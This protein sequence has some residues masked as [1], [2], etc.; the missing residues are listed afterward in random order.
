MT[1]IR[2]T[3]FGLSYPIYSG[4][5]RSLKKTLFRNVRQNIKKI[6]PVGGEVVM[7]N[8]VAVVRALHEITF[9]IH[10]GERVGLIGHNGAGK[11]TLLR[12]IAGIFES[13]QGDLHIQGDVHSLLDAGAGMNPDLTGRENIRLY[14]ASLGY[15]RQVSQSLEQ[16]V[17]AFAELGAFLDMPVR[18]Y[19][20]GMGVRL[21]FALATAPRPDILLMDE[22]F[23]AG[24]QG[25]HERAEQRLHS[26]VDHADILVLTSH[27]LHVLRKWCT[28]I[29]WLEHGRMRMDGPAKD[30][31]DA[32]EA[33]ASNGN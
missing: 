1:Q 18:L 30:I 31:L 9:T 25:F 5:A 7:E 21:G 12:A 11:S 3:R 27:E 15:S 23:M 20:A 17:E 8:N 24:D 16:D 26:L 13:S 14:A 10:A 32:Y 19:S 6:S 2:L 33:A 4:N 28:R 22:W 29:I